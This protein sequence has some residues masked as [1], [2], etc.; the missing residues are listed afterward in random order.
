M[1]TDKNGNLLAAVSEKNC[2]LIKFNGEKYEIIFEPKDDIYIFAIA[3]DQKGD[4]YLGTGPNGRIYRLNPNGKNPKLIYTMPD[5]NVISLA[6]GNDG[7]V[8]AGCD[9]RGIVY[10]INPDAKAA[11]VLF[12]SEQLE[13]SSLI[14]DNDGSLYVAATS[15]RA[16]QI[17]SRFNSIS[18]QASPGRPDTDQGSPQ[19]NLI[20][21]NDTILTIANT[22][23]TKGTGGNDDSGRKKRLSAP[24]SASRVY[25]ITPEGFVTDIF[26]ELAVFFS[27]ASHNDRLLLA[28]G[29]NA[30]LFTVDPVTEQKAVDYE[31][32]QSSQITAITSS[33]GCVYLGCSNPAKL[34]K[35]ADSFAEQGYFVSDIVDASQPAM[36]GKLQIDADIPEQCRIL[37]SARSG[38]V[39][40]PNDPTFSPWTA[41]VALTQATQLTCPLGRFCQYKLSLQTSLPDKSPVIREI[42]VPYVVQNLPPKIKSVKVTRPDSKT[43]LYNLQI[44]YKAEDKNKDTLIYTIEFRKLGR[45]N[46]IE[47]EEKLTNDEYNWDTRTV[48][49]GRYEIKV[50]AN[51]QRSNSSATY[52]TASRISDPFVIDN[53]PPAIEGSQVTVKDRTATVTFKVKDDFTA[54]GK[55]SYTVDSNSD[56]IATLPEDIVY[57]TTEEY[58]KITLEEMHQGFHVLALRVSDDIGNTLY[59]T[60]DI[61]IME[62]N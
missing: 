58:L 26:S 39:K 49:D 62:N 47:L 51:D 19:T 24:K 54:I 5:K 16:A 13:I 25:K 12:D 45:S 4:I 55:V 46:W 36:W 35:L 38:N 10:K 53:T 37:M 6:L 28:T 52:L 7:F 56:W 3:I 33:D 42:A 34:I 43:K 20:I 2:Q 32:K 30:K 9:Q 23:K 18:A 61:N 14:F 17:Q 60:F 29:N 21:K 1:T 27:I 11:S 50:T 48:E 59:K 57:D 40:D 44:K 15:A 41:P 8:Y 31:D 22:Q